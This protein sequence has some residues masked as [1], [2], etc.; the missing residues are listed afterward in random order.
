MCFEQ[1]FNLVVRVQHE[2]IEWV[3]IQGRVVT[4][5]GRGMEGKE[6]ETGKAEREGTRG[7]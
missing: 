2:L 1:L 7:K 6:E 5:W 3:V 4:V